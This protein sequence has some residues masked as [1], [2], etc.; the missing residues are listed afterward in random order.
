MTCLSTAL[1]PCVAAQLSL[2]AARTLA[3][4]ARALA[5]APLPAWPATPPGGVMGPSWASGH[6]GHCARPFCVSPSAKKMSGPVPVRFFGNFWARCNDSQIPSGLRRK[7]RATG[8][9]PPSKNR[10]AA[11]AQYRWWKI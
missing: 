11:G 1:A 2:T 5:A 4:W 7:M 8:N 10:A 6:R 3:C 9:R